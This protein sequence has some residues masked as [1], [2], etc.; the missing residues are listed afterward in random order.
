MERGA[1]GIRVITMNHSAAHAGVILDS[2]WIQ[3][4]RHHHVCALVI[5][6]LQKLHAVV[7]VKL[8][9]LPSPILDDDMVAMK[10]K[11]PVAVSSITKRIDIGCAT[12][13]FSLVDYFQDLVKV[14][15]P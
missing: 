12:I 8:Q 13:G 3:E 15:K 7:F 9:H 6:V 4:R 10:R 2:V 5:V 1:V 14:F 11:G